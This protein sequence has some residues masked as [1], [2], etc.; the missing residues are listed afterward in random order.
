ML[1][2]TEVIGLIITIICKSVINENK[3]LSYSKKFKFKE[4]LVIYILLIITVI[5]MMVYYHIQLYN[6]LIYIFITLQILTIEGKIN[7]RK[8]KRQNLNNGFI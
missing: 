5:H 3:S 8:T 7:E 4:L 1:I 2:F 6:F